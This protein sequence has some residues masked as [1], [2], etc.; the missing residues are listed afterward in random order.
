MQPPA[1][2]A[3][4]SPGAAY[5]QGQP[6]GMMMAPMQQMQPPPLHQ[7]D[8][9]QQHTQ[10]F[11]LQLQHPPASTDPDP[12]AVNGYA[13]HSWQR[14]GYS[15]HSWQQKQL[16]RRKTLE[17]AYAFHAR[18]VSATL[19]NL[20]AVNAAVRE[21]R[22]VG[23]KGTLSRRL[24]QGECYDTIVTAAAA[25]RELVALDW[26]IAMGQDIPPGASPFAP[27]AAAAKDAAADARS[28]ADIAQRATG[29]SGTIRVVNTAVDNIK[30][31]LI[32]VPPHEFLDED[33]LEDYEERNAQ[34]RKWRY[35]A[36]AVLAACAVVF[37]IVAVF[38]TYVKWIVAVGNLGGQFSTVQ[39]ALVFSADAAFWIVG[40]VHLAF[41][42]PRKKR[43]LNAKKAASEFMDRAKGVMLS[44][45]QQRPPQPNQA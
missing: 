8:S 5:G 30:T 34:S 24:A 4:S 38:G 28:G 22:L 13:K 26:A 27:I 43:R 6:P 42:L 18:Q 2:M 17:V 25:R 45:A 40:L 10:Q 29:I 23:A 37:S 7:Q 11:Q 15:L 16:V 44:K 3:P 33:A 39:G 21:K 12:A 35:A 19:N 31:Q 36:H 1:M 32:G 41:A 14:N 9:L 20:H